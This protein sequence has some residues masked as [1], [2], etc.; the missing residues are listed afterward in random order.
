MPEQDQPAAARSR[1]AV[2]SAAP[3]AAAEAAR[4]EAERLLADGY[5]VLLLTPAFGKRKPDP[6]RGGVHVVE[7]RVGT[8]FDSAPGAL[9][10][11]GRKA[12]L[13][14]RNARGKALGNP[15]ATWSAADI[16]AEIGPYLDAFAP[17]VVVACDKTAEKAV[18]K[19]GRAAVAPGKAQSK[20]ESPAQ[21]SLL[22]GSNNNA[23]MGYA[24]ARAVRE[25]AGIT[26]RN[27]QKK[28]YAFAYGS[29][30]KAED[31]D[32]VDPL[33]GLARVADTL[34][35]VTH[36]LSE[37]GLAVFGRLNGGL[38]ADDLPELRR[39]G[40]RSGL[41][42]HGS[43]IRS[44]DR[45][46]ELYKFSPFRAPVS[47]EDQ[48]LTEV[49]RGK[50]DEMAK[51]VAEFDGPVFVSTPDLIDD[52]PHATWLP[53][54]VDLEQ[55]TEGTRAPLEREVP[56]VVHAP[57]RPFM[58][59]SDLIEPTL[60]DL[61]SRGL[62]EYRRLE[63]IPQADLVGVVQDADIV[64]DHFV[65]GNYGVMTCQAMAAG[66]VSI[67]NIDQR[68]RDR[69]PAEIPTIQADPDSLGEVIEGVLADRDKARA[70]AAT[71]RA[72]VREFHDGRKS[73][74]AIGPWLRGA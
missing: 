65:I 38:L 51:W 14:T 9:G 59:G 20:A 44:P 70:V 26:A 61:E 13:T 39:A 52:V 23:G 22:I 10:K 7:V 31:K 6:S 19:I 72:F 40:I 41:L 46:I 29:D 18:A 5:S 15:A 25:H 69:V 28:S 54:V 56:V 63:H 58:K 62:I 42:F 36:V 30:I 49:L 66:R 57:S 50:T 34:D 45:H 43:D 67:A 68:V 64:L 47:E 2:V 16:A 3:A 12:V 73:A 33:W 24:W 74:E 32:W 1:A 53:V 71:G 17:D 11:I 60:R 55:W 35:T 21:P 4:A 8:S 48:K 27:I 37:S